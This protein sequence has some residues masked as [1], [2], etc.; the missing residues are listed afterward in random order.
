MLINEY[1]MGK[2]LE[3]ETQR[4]DLYDLYVAAQANI[5]KYRPQNYIN[6][7]ILPVIESVL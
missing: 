6:N 3:R 4:T 1:Q 5:D 2:Q 7:Y